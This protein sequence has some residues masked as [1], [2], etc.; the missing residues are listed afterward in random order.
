[1]TKKE[2]FRQWIAERTTA[3]VKQAKQKAMC[4]CY[5]CRTGSRYGCNRI[6]A[7]A[8]SYLQAVIE[9]MNDYV[10]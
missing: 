2:L 4:D 10:G 9:E 7:S 6:A 8:P 3:E 1:M 5:G